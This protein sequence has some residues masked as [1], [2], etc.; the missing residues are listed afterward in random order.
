MNQRVLTLTLAACVATPAVAFAGMPSVD[1]TDVARMRIETLSFFLVVF[2]GCGKGL[3]LLWNWLR[4]DFTRLPRLSYCKALGLLT[5]WG[6]LFVVVLTMIS[7]AR[8][9]LT[10]GAW[11][12]V[13]V[14]Y[15]L[16]GPKADEPAVDYTSDTVRRAKLERL[17]DALWAY[18]RGHDGQLPASPTDPDIAAEFWQTTDPSAVA[19]LYVAGRKPHVG[20]EVLAFEPRVFGDG[21]FALFTSGEIRKLAATELEAM[22]PKEGRP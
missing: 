5:V 22:L 9:L 16:A 21:Q 4:N 14:T 1:L 11:E 17:R 18:A 15:R 2:L 10:P 3:Q 6:L 13:G 7:G 19:Y 12:K 20:A 8:E